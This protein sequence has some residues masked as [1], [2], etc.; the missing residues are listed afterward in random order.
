MQAP[1][2]DLVLEFL[3]E[4]LE[5]FGMLMNGMDIFLKDD[6][7]SR[8]GADDFREPPEVGRAPVGPARVAD[9]VSEQEGFE[10]ELGVFKIADGVFTRPGEIPDG[11]IC[12]LWG[13]R[14]R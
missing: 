6:L 7:L 8:C 5:S 10:P 9:I 3:F 1:R 13:H 12:H 11:F 2:C 4:T 14:P